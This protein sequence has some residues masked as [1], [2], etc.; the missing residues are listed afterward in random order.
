MQNGLLPEPG[1]LAR[2]TEE[3]EKDRNRVWIMV[4]KCAKMDEK[5]WCGGHGEFAHDWI[6]W[7][8]HKMYQIKKPHPRPFEDYLRGVSS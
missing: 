1:D 6:E 7:D 2:W 4:S 8:Y 3:Y 5:H